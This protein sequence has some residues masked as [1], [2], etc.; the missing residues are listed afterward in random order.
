MDDMSGFNKKVKLD[1]EDFY[2]SPE[3]YIVFTLDNRGSENR[4]RDFEHVIYRDLGTNEIEDQMKGVEYLKAQSKQNP[5]YGRL[6]LHL[7][8]QKKILVRNVPLNS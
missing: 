8:F 7:I 2:Y 6:R 5:C 4:G 3:G 1:P